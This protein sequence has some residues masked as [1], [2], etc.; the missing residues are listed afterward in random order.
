TAPFMNTVTRAFPGPSAP[1]RSV[2]KRHGDRARTGQPRH[3]VTGAPAGS[4]VTI[5]GQFY[6][7]ICH[8]SIR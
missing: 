8:G 2:G 6:F 1:Y 5:I 4:V 7:A 3:Q